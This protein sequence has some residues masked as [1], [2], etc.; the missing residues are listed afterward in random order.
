MRSPARPKRSGPLGRAPW[1]VLGALVLHIL[2]EWPDFPE[3]ATRHFGTTSPGFFIVSHLPIVGFVGWAMWSATRPT[4]RPWAIWVLGLILAALGTNVLFHAGAS[5]ALREL[6]PGIFSA[7]VLYIPLVA[8]LLPGVARVLGRR[9]TA[10]AVAAGVLIAL[11]ITG[12]LWLD[13]PAP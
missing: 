3:W 1:L 9:R 10:E 6:A 8:Y 2:E 13:F 5:V 11:L 7:V 12:S 4:P